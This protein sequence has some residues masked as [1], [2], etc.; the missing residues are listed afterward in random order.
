M[1]YGISEIRSAHNHFAKRQQKAFQQGVPEKENERKRNL[2]CP[3]PTELIG[4]KNID[5]K[6]DFEKKEKK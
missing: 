4:I 2:L 6:L 1:K 3:Y 5:S